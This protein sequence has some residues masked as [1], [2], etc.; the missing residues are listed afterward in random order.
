MPADLQDYLALLAQAGP[1]LEDQLLREICEGSLYDFLKESWHAFDPA[2]FVGG[3]H[4]EAIAEHLQ[5]VS[6][7]QIRKLLINIRPRSTKTSLVAIAWPTWTWALQPRADRPLYGPGVRFLCGSYGA[8]KAQEDGV[9]ARRLIG[10][11][12]YQRL[13]GN[14]VKITNSRDN[15]ERYD[16]T[17]GGSR[18]NTGI[19]E[20]L[21]KGG[22]IRVLDDVHKTNEVESETMRG[23]VIRGYKEVWSTRTNDPAAGAEVMVMQRQAEDDLS[24]Y[25][26]EQ[27][28]P[29][30]VHLCI[31]AWHESD[32]ACTTYIDM[33]G[34]IYSNPPSGV[35]VDVF[36]QDP[37]EEDGES[38]WPIRYPPKERAVDE[39]L[40]PFAF[41]SQIQQ[42]P[43]PR[44]GGIIKRMWW[45][46][47]PPDDAIERW[48]NPQG[49]S[50]FPPWEHVVGYLDSAFTKKETNDWCAMTRLGVFGDDAGR[51]RV[52]LAGAWRERLNFQELIAKVA[53]TC[54]AGKVD[55]LVIENK[56]GGNWIAEELVK[57]MRNGEWQI[58]LDTP[59]VDKVARAHAVVPLFVDRAVFAPFLHDQGVWRVWAEMVIS[60]VE[61]FP[62]G[63]HDDLVDCMSGGLGYLRRNDLIRL[64]SEYEEDERESKTFRGNREGV[65]NMYGVGD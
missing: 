29:E 27:G 3:W 65:A 40:G 30:T 61:K 47:W 24:G 38:F 8:N 21:G 6:N 54:R 15:Q 10:S 36:W 52:M 31:P 44:G 11:E 7:G 55:T 25:W 48:T 53:A 45:Q 49:Q 20:S 39:A 37:R 46:A 23:A 58:V 59:T 12:W 57:E 51:P 4:L 35:E 18:I 13:W 22:M 9:T 60:E 32:R 42:R 14:R 34:R 1:E 2:P 5:A 50:I 64:S 17:S 62:M 41:A 19:P 33:K 43:E 63:R 56:A 16:T 28:G 26:L